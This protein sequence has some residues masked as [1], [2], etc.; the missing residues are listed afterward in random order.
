MP[1]PR[2]GLRVRPWAVPAGRSVGP[3]ALRRGRS[4]FYAESPTGLKTATRIIPALPGFAPL[5]IVRSDHCIL[6]TLRESGRPGADGHPEGGRVPVFVPDRLPSV[7]N[8]APSTIRV[9]PVTKPP[10]GAEIESAAAVT[11]RQASASSP[12]RRGRACRRGRN[13]GRDRSSQTVREDAVDQDEGDA[14]GQARAVRPGVVGAALDHDVAG[15]HHGLHPR[16]GAG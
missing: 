4:M 7:I 3:A 13:S 6:E 5:A 8:V 14:A 16:R 10:P 11:S 1:A 12:P 15:P 9:C 2:H